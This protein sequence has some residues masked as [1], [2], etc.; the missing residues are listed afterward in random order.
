M[1][2]EHKMVHEGKK[3]VTKKY[4]SCRGCVFEREGTFGCNFY[5]VIG[6]T[7]T[8]KCLP[9]YYKD[10]CSRIWVEDKSKNKPAA[11]TKGNFCYWVI[12]EFIEDRWVGV[13]VHVTRAIARDAQ[14]LYIGKTRVR[15]FVEVK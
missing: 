15:K 13:A 14:E 10:G 12:E 4:E 6:E 7:K 3:Y 5:E 8:N 2:K 11:K 9:A 1:S